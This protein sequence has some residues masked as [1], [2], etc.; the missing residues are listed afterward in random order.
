MLKVQE[1]DR[2]GWRLPGR[3]TAKVGSSA[4]RK[5]RETTIAQFVSWGIWENRSLWVFQGHTKLK[6]DILFHI[7]ECPSLSAHFLCSSSFCTYGI[8]IRQQCLISSWSQWCR[9]FLETFPPIT[10]KNWRS[11]SM[12]REEFENPATRQVRMALCLHLWFHCGE[13]G[14]KKQKERTSLL[15]TDEHWASKVD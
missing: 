5:T 12:F 4:N 14:P 13:K 15:G 2:K 1:A 8:F 7:P 11:A 10:V 6:S 3:M 9:I